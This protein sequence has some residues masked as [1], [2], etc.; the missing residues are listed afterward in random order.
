VLQLKAA[1]LSIGQIAAKL[2]VGYSTVRS[3]LKMV[4]LKPSK[5][6]DEKTA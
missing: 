1:G 6:A 3:R 4:S 5:T 2:G